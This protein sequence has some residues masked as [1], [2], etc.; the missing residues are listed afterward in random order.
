MNHE[1]IDPRRLGAAMMNSAAIAIA[2]V[3]HGEIVFA[4]PAFVAIFRAAGSLIG[5]PF[6]EF[7]ADADGDRVTAALAAARQSPSRCFA[8]GRRGDDP[9]FDL[10][11]SLECAVFDD[12]PLV[13]AFAWDATEQQR[14]RERLTF[15][16]YTD[17]LTGLANRSLFADRLHD[18]MLCARRHA[19]AFAVLALDL[20]GFKAVNDTYG[21]DLGDLAL[22]TVAQRFRGCL[23][24]SDTLAR[25]GGDE[26]AVLLPRLSDRQAA[27]LVA[28]RMIAALAAPLDFGA[29]PV[30][31]GTSIGIATWPEHAG[32]VDA[33]L[34]AADTAMYRAKRGG[35]NRVC[36]AVRHSGRDSASLPPLTWSAAHAVGIQEID[37]Q[38]EHLARLVDRLSTA[39]KDGLDSETTLAGVN[40]VI[41]YAAF[42]F[43]TEERLMEQHQL[44]DLARHRVEHR[45][46]LHDIRHLR[47]DGDLAS[48]SL[49]LRFLQEWLLRHVDGLD[50]QLGQALIA[51]GCR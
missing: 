47:V 48:V 43:A 10:E 12:E 32:S 30:E 29:S 44:A 18:A 26:F 41:R 35:R 40:E 37:E 1:R 3:R 8:A 42:H 45:R 33:L 27:E 14:C 22:Q 7:V 25:I 23:R 36:W 4:N 15:L 13:I 6:T 5:V 31:I 11:L 46:L 50:R 21:H 34:T 39:L 20:D 16:A 19:T 28:Q 24:D 49:I 2:V 51:L 9:P 38:H 17:P